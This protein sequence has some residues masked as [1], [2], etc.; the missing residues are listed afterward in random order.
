[1]NSNWFSREV[2]YQF[3]KTTIDGDPTLRIFREDRRPTCVTLRGNRIWVNSYFGDLPFGLFEFKKLAD[4]V[5][6]NLTIDWKPQK[7][8]KT[9][10]ILKTWVK[11]QCAKSISKSLNEWRKEA[12]LKI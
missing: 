4:K 11:N 7:P 5:A 3:E 2:M 1:M 8:T 12:L 6:E 9:P 10:G